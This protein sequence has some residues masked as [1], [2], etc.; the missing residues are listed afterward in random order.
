MS[1]TDPKEDPKPEGDKPE[2]TDDKVSQAEI[3][4]WKA[5][6]RKHEAQAKAN[7]EKARK[8]DESEEANR[9]ETEKA[10]AKAAEAEKRAQE[11]ELKALR[12]EVAANKGLSPA[13]A[14][15]L[16]GTTIEELESDADEL[17]ESFK[18]SDD[19]RTP[20]AG[21]PRE[22]LR[23][24]GD[25]SESPEELDPHKLAQAIPRF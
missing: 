11:A 10:A 23:G 19:N 6:A 24:G 15:R 21:K 7:A 9:S 8:F 16:V 2:G 20:P 14:K 13:Q 4:K 25:P 18:P 12:L 3:D 22:D 1:D 5:M 17:L